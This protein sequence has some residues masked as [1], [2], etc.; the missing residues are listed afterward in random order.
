MILLRVPM[1]RALPVLAAAIALGAAA[2]AP[3]PS[4][5]MPV[6]VESAFRDL[7]AAYRSAPTTERITLSLR[8]PPAPSLPA[9]DRSETYIVTLNPSA[10]APADP[11][12]AAP[13]LHID[14]GPLQLWATQRRVIGLLASD[15][16]RYA[17]L[18]VSPPF[19]AESLAR[20]IPPLA[21]PQ[22]D[23]AL[24]DSARPPTTITPYARGIAWTQATVDDADDPTEVTI[25]GATD[26]GPITLVSDAKSGMLRE[27]RINSR[28]TLLR[29]TLEPLATQPGSLTLPNVDDRQRLDSL[30]DLRSS[31]EPAKIGA[32]TPPL[33]LMRT[34][35]TAWTPPPAPVV[36]I[37][38]RASAAGPDPGDP[39]AVALAARR[40]WTDTTPASSPLDIRPVAVFDLATAG[41]YDR[42][43]ETARRWTQPPA[44]RTAESGN[45]A[46]PAK[47][48]GGMGGVLWS[49]SE[50][51]TLAYFAPGSTAA[52]VVID[53]Q[54]RLRAVIP[55]TR[56]ITPDALR[57]QVRRSLAAPDP[58]P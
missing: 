20:A 3:A 50:T 2:P 47:G 18:P 23:L 48:E 57:D 21:L 13:L 24:S 14:F 17:D 26:A 8:R 55:L 33:S 44:D 6:P 30:A 22:L 52:A 29:L 5:P 9:I 36:L 38:F 56:E 54:Q 27:V 16:A 35:N 12:P 11:P 28:G 31:I 49:H 10:L 34:D 53:P 37:M 46:D 41:L 15:S 51:T 58:D 42:V 4:G 40:A 1:L 32:R 39:E 45:A 43:R 7:R 19:S 25:N